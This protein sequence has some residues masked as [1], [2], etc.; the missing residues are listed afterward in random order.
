M[1]KVIVIVLCLFC[2]PMAFS[3]SIWKKIGDEAKK[4]VKETTKGVTNSLSSSKDANNGKEKNNVNTTSLKSEIPTLKLGDVRYNIP[5]LTPNTKFL[6]IPINSIVSDIYDGAFSV[7][8]ENKLA[9]Y[10][11]SGDCIFGFISQSINNKFTPEFN[12]GVCLVRSIEK[13]GDI[14][15]LVILY[16]NGKMVE[17]KTQYVEGTQFKDGIARVLKR[18]EGAKYQW[19]HINQGGAEIFPNL[20]SPIKYY[21]NSD[22]ELYPISEGLRACYDYESERWGFINNSGEYV[23]KPKYEKVHSFKDGLAAVSMSK[24]SPTWGFIDKTGKMIIEPKFSCSSESIGDFENGIVLFVNHK[25][26][27]KFEY[28]DKTGKL[29]KSYNE[30]SPFHSGFAFVRTQPQHI[31]AEVTV[32]D[33]NFNKVRRLPKFDILPANGYLLQF[34]PQGRIASIKGKKAIDNSGNIVLNIADYRDRIEDFSEDLIAKGNLIY[35]NTHFSGFLNAWGEYILVYN[36]KRLDDIVIESSKI[37]NEKYNI[38]NLEA[39]DSSVFPPRFKLKLANEKSRGPKEVIQPTYNV[40]TQVEPLNGGVIK[41]GGTYKFG[42]NVN[43]KIQAN[44]DYKLSYVSS[45]DNSI[46]LTKGEGN[47]SINGDDVIITAHF[48]KRDI[49]D[50]PNKSQILS[51]SHKLNVPNDPI[52]NIPAIVYGEIS[53]DSISSK[54]GTNTKGFLTI[55]LD[56]DKFYECTARLTQT[57]CPSNPVQE[58]VA[59]AKFYILPMKVIGFMKEKD[60]NY[61]VVEGGQLMMGGINIDFPSNPIMNLYLKSIMAFNGNL[62]STI[63]NARYR[64]ELIDYMPESK[65]MTFGNMEAYSTTYGWLLSDDKTFKSSQNRDRKSVV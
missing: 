2:I 56:S 36:H 11:K 43:V 9:Y 18:F 63:S 5:H 16:K 19:V 44:K 42:E 51:G 20:N 7:K 58:G 55:I 31:E 46:D 13:K 10:D 34:D 30:A 21:R 39:Q 59:K 48:L 49:I 26:Q 22:E 14:F 40:R 12:K 64:I 1:R 54:Y 45:S 8:S 24:Y 60:K 41:G 57:V 50:E 15:P 62:V 25:A 38:I 33:E 28:Y 4:S 17:L 35:D 53:K 61:L 37:Q 65:K 32:I 27:N 52:C 29:L 6:Q 47:F 23:I 3:D